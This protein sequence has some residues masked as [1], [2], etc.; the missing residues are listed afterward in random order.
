M[1]EYRFYLCRNQVVIKALMFDEPTDA[2]ARER[3]TRLLKH[4][5]YHTA[6]IWQGLR[7]VATLEQDTFG[8]TS[9]PAVAKSA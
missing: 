4:S 1:A 5:D 8:Q 2:W 7:L 6:E 3:A 9:V